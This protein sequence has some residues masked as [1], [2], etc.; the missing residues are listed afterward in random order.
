MFYEIVVFT[1]SYEVE[2][3]TCE[4]QFSERPQSAL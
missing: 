1:F 4:P 3:A 2:G